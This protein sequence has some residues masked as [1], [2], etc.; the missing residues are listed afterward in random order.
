MAVAAAELGVWMVGNWL[1]IVSTGFVMSV[2]RYSLVLF[3]LFVWAA[4]LAE[5]WRR[6]GWLLGGASAAAMAY[7]TWRFASGAWAF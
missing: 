4:L 6:A 7:F 3:G 5:R 1:L 2:P